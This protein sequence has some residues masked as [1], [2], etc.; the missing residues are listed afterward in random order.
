MAFSEEQLASLSR[1][2]EERERRT[3]RIAWVVTVIPIILAALLLAY[4][5]RQISIKQVELDQI[6]N[7]SLILRTQILQDQDALEKARADISQANESLA[8]T[9]AQLSFTTSQLAITAAQLR[10]VQLELEEYQ[11]FG[12]YAC[13]L[14]EESVKEYES[15]YTP[16]AQVLGYLLESGSSYYSI[17]WNPQGFSE[18]E[19]FDSPNYALFVLQK[20]GLVS[21][22][23]QPGT[24][25]WQILPSTTEPEN[26]DIIYYE[27]GFAMFYYNLPAKY[28]SSETSECVIGMTP[29]KVLSET[30]D[31]A[32][33]LGILKVPYP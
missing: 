17:P 28:G 7:E 27:S 13:Q 21:Q 10:N 32:K 11:V 26:G 2:I 8:T 15:N 3:R 22:E 12:R 16:Q 9:T 1:R 25:P 31:F 19:G 14:N 20:F 30:I 18:V 4:T 6:E 29:L 33:P 23:Y 5:I 24:L